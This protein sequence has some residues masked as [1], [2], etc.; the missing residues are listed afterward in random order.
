MIR[1]HVKEILEESGV[2]PLN[3]ELTVQEGTGNAIFMNCS[4]LLENDPKRP[5]K[6]STLI[7]IVV[8]GHATD[9]FRQADSKMLKQLNES[10]IRVVTHRMRGYTAD[11]GLPYDKA[12]KPFD[13]HIAPIDLD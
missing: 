3:A 8:H 5:N 7:R 1:E 4:W 9:L 12:P 2:F 13:I 11:Q 10:L 6:R